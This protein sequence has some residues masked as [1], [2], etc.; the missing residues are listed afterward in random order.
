[1]IVG[2]VAVPAAAVAAAGV[3]EGI[4]GVVAAVAVAVT[5]GQAEKNRR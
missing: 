2:V 4:V 5:V 1:V 3:E